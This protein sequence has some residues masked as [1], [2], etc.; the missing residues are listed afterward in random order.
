MSTIRS[1]RKAPSETWG[2]EWSEGETSAL[3]L[4]AGSWRPARTGSAERPRPD[5]RT[6]NQLLDEADCHITF[7]RVIQLRSVCGALKSPSATCKQMDQVFPPRRAH[8]V[9]NGEKGL[10]LSRGLNAAPKDV[11]RIERGGRGGNPISVSGTHIGTPSGA[12]RMAGDAMSQ[13]S[14]SG[15]YASVG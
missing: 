1:G 2:T 8:D 7:G 12:L 10:N 6:P 11:R 5:P 13:N 9:S 3:R 14:A 15:M 4:L